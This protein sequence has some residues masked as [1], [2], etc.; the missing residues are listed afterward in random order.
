[1][2]Y[3]ETGTYSYTIS[4]IETVVRRFTADLGMIAQSSGAVT[5][6]KAWEYAHDIE[7]LAREGFLE[8]VDIT[9]L[10]AF[11]EIKAVQYVVNKSA[12]DLE[13]SRPGGVLWPVVNY[14]FLRIIL[15]Y[16]DAY[17]A[18]ARNEM[19]SKLKI[20]WVPTRTDTSHSGL[21]LSG[22][23]TFSSNGW[24]MERRDFN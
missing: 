13:M 21:R 18:D 24:G 6:A 5:E 23:R 17:D 16:S 12:G 2:T 19:E 10:S 15:W 20:R 7:L 11:K 8:I 9:L 14:P 4:D 22:G 3:T 1:M